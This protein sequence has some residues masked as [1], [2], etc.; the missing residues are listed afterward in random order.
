MSLNE[1]PSDMNSPDENSEQVVADKFTVVLQLDGP[2][3][4]IT[5]SGYRYH[6][7]LIPAKAVF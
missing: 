7:R 4:V 2:Y 5:I 3:I 6:Y 1:S